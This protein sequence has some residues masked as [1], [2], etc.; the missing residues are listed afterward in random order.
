MTYPEYY[1]NY[2][3]MRIYRDDGVV[4]GMVSTY[5][6]GGRLVAWSANPYWIEQAADDF[7]VSLDKFEA[8][9]KRGV[10]QPWQEDLVDGCWSNWA[11]EAQGIRQA[12]GRQ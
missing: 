2:R 8:D 11:N 10:R 3:R 4:Y 12:E 7:V 6:R 1:W 5:Y 9:L